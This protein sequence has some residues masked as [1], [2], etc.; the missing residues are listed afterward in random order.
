MFYSDNLK[1]YAGII[2]QAVDDLI[3][4]LR[5]AAKTGEQVDMHGQLGRLTMQ[6][7]GAA[8]FGYDCELSI[9]GLETIQAAF[10][11][12]GIHVTSCYPGVELLLH[13]LHTAV[14]TC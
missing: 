6:V 12:L 8:A 3:N 2:N 11:G 4:N 7:I 10:L 9:S 1:E 14:C 13:T 5:A